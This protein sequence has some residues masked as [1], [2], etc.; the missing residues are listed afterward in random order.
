MRHGTQL[1]CGT[2][3]LARWSW[4]M[5]LVAVGLLIAEWNGISIDELRRGNHI[6]PIRKTEAFIVATGVAIFYK[7]VEAGR[8]AGR[9]KQ[10]NGRGR[11]IAQYAAWGF[12][13]ASTTLPVWAVGWH[14]S[15]PS[16]GKISRTSENEAHQ[17]QVSRN[18]VS[19]AMESLRNGHIDR[20]RKNLVE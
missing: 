12:A 10:P 6:K 2:D 20:A 1:R 7:L 14:L 13:I 4:M 5:V 11:T 16:R 17:R 15:I 8:I 9:R 18:R 3:E 19:A